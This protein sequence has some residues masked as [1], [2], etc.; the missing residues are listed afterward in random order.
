[1]R[2]WYEFRWPYLLGA[3]L[4]VLAVT[5]RIERPDRRS[6][7]SAADIE[8]LAQ[9]KDVNVLFIL[10]DMLRADR[11]GA[12]G[13]SRETS[14]TLDY[15][16]QRGVL[17]RRH[18]SQSSW[19][20]SSMASLWTS[21]YPL[22]AG[23]TRYDDSLPEEARLPAE[24]LKEAGFHTVGLYR[25]GWVAPTF[26]FAQG[27]DSY[28][29]PIGKGVPRTAIIKNPTLREGATDYDILRSAGEFLRVRG[30]ERWFLYLHMMD[31]HEYVYDE[32]TAIFGSRYSDIYDS[33]I[34]RVDRV[35]EVLLGDLAKDGLLENTLVVITADHGEAFLERGFEGHARNLYRE[36]QEI[37]LILSFPFRLEPGIALDVR[38]QGVDVWPTLLDLLGLPPLQPSDGRSFR[39]EILAAARGEAVREPER[40]AV[41]F[42]D[43][44]WGTPNVPPAQT[45]SVVAGSQRY[46]LTH[47]RLGT[48]RKLEE[49]FDAN[50]D[51]GELVDHFPE[52]PDAA[53]PLQEQAAEQLAAGIVWS[54]APAKLELDEL[55]LNQLRALGYELP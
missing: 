15:L 52:K 40:S 9:R 50:D 45:I 44:R 32:S 14:P 12:Y 31:V 19:T 30:R 27:Y 1:M 4:I 49:L 21:L 18:L 51:P 11:L 46:V 25:N 41:A 3:V 20:K 5:L 54:Q 48:D 47:D 28:E 22:R 7:G 35:I 10:I 29:R 23:I 17:F 6:R 2:R 43:Q 38:T 34:R 55:Q 8:Q 26:G 42:L 16:A 53:R 37:P 13:Y 36:T 39:P 33:A 24:I